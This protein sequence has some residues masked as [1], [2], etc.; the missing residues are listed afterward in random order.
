[1]NRS[2]ASSPENTRSIR[3]ILK[4]N[5]IAG[6]ASHFCRDE[7]SFIGRPDDFLKVLSLKGAGKLPKSEL[8]RLKARVAAGDMDTRGTHW[9][10]FRR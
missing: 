3:A 7:Y 5:N 9:F 6:V 4:G 2:T 1:M 10:K 8:E